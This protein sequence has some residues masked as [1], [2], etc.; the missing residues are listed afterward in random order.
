[1]PNESNKIICN[2]YPIKDYRFKTDCEK[3]PQTKEDC[4]CTKYNYDMGDIQLIGWDLLMS[5]STRVEEYQRTYNFLYD[6][7]HCIEARDR[8]PEERCE[9]FN[10]KAVYDLN[11]TEVIGCG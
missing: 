8:T 4:I 6:N 5:N 3:N 9:Y 10:K 1:M 2:E 7:T 11:N